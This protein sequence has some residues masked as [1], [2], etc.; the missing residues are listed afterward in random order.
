MKRLFVLLILVG[1]ALPANAGTPVILVFGDSIS[2]GYGLR[3]LKQ[4]WVALLQAKLKPKGTVT[5]SSMPA[6]AARRPRGGSR[7]C[8]A[9]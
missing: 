5:R 2:A 1:A 7:A 8:R 6:S 3:A 4:G 9:P